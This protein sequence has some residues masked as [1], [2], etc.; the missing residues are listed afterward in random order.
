[1]GTAERGRETEGE[2]EKTKRE[3]WTT[4]RRGYDKRME[5]P[6]GEEWQVCGIC[7]HS[8]YDILSEYLL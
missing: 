7:S 6:T 4:E 8:L 5:E 1:V 2:R 3:T